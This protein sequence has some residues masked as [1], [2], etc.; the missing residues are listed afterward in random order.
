MYLNMWHG[1]LANVHLFVVKRILELKLICFFASISIAIYRN[2]VISI[3]FTVSI[4][5]FVAVM[6]GVYADMGQLA[7]LL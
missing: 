6:T 5:V 2:N 3:V 1:K 4:V 7:N